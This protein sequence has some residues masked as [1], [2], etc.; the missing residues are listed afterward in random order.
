ML[1]VAALFGCG[2]FGCS[3]EVSAPATP[4]H[5]PVTVAVASS[6]RVVPPAP[7]ASASGSAA[8]LPAPALETFSPD[9]HH[10]ADAKLTRADFEG[11][12]L[13]HNGFTFGEVVGD[14]LTFRPCWSKGL[15]KL[16]IRRTLG[17]W[18]DDAYVLAVQLHTTDYLMRWDRFGKRWRVVAAVTNRSTAHHTYLERAPDGLG[19]IGLQMTDPVVFKR[20]TTKVAASPV[21]VAPDGCTAH[22][23]YQFIEGDFLVNAQGLFAACRFAAEHWPKGKTA[24]LVSTL[25]GLDN[26]GVQLVDH[27]GSALLLAGTQDKTPYVARFDGNDWTQLKP[28]ARGRLEHVGRTPSGDTALY[29]AETRTLWTL[30]A[31]DAW[32]SELLP[33]ALSTN[34]SNWR[35]LWPKWETWLSTANG[36]WAKGDGVDAGILHRRK[37]GAWRRVHRDI[38]IDVTQWHGHLIYYN[39]TATFSVDKLDVKGM[40]I[41]PADAAMP[42]HRNLPKCLR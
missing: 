30:N 32:S 18:P 26:R 42:D 35:D 10:V 39:G 27:R 13:V 38:A 21:K 1:V 7:D 9:V 19:L 11:A 15:G 16:Q 41:A 33:F 12:A 25:S 17:R 31:R 14:T 4:P 29:E 40:P 34:E 3:G 6:V 23:G 37:G 8:P 36:V 2:G 24:S 22:Q 5:A 28:G 20:F